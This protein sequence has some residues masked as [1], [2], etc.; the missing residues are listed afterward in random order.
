MPAA[1]TALAIAQSRYFV[2]AADE[3]RGG[4]Q[5]EAEHPAEEG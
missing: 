1:A 2:A 3:R 4:D 5:C